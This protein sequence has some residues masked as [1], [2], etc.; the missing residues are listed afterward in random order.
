M[1]ITKK[2][3]NE[4]LEMA[5]PLIKWINENCHPH[6]ECIVDMTTVKLVEGVAANKTDEFI[7][8]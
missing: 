8:D 2:Q 7:K 1:T 3:M 6:C 5:K 4:M